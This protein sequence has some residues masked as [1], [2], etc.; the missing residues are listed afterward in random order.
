MNG[1]INKVM[2]LIYRFLLLM[3]FATVASSCVSNIMI[4][5]YNLSVH[6]VQLSTNEGTEIGKVADYLL[7]SI[8][9]DKKLSDYSNATVQLRGKVILANQKKYLELGIIG[10][11]IKE[12]VY[13]SLESMND[14]YRKK[15]NSEYTAFFFRY[16]KLDYD[17]RFELDLLEDEYERI[18]FN[19]S[20]RV[21]AGPQL[22]TSEIITFT[23]ND[24]LNIYKERLNTGSIV[25]L[26][27]K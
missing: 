15:I 5:D 6:Q 27:I 3:G 26:I 12:N 19:I 9:T 8:I 10:S 16:I 21:Y 20:Y 25:S 14:L 18:E 13:K 4:K 2:R 23:K 1:V 24:I 17:G 22:G 11:E 7:F